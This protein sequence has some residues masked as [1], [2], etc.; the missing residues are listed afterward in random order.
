MMRQLFVCFAGASLSLW[1]QMPTGPVVSP[2]WVINAFTQQPAPSTVAPGGIIW[3]NGINLSPPGGGQASGSPL[4]TKLTEAE[5]EVLI[6]GRSAPLYSV[7]PSR[8][9]AQV[10]WEVRAGLAQVVVRRGGDQSR[11][12]RIFVNNMLPALRARQDKGYGEAVAA[13]T[14]STMK[15][16]ATGLGDTDP[17]VA[18]G[19]TG[20]AD[21]PAAPRAAVEVWVGGARSKTTAVVSTERV[22]EFDITVEI[23]A[24]ANPG[25]IITLAAGGRPSNRLTYRNVSQA[26]VS[27][28]P[29]PEDA[30]EMRGILSSDLRGDYV[31]TSSGRNEEGCWPAWVFDFRKKAVTKID[32]CLVAANRNAAMPFSMSNEGSALGAL[33]GPAQGE[34]Q[35]GISSKV[36]VLNPS[37]G[38]PMRLDL[39]AAVSNVAS[40]PG[41]NLNAVAPGTPPRAFRIDVETGEVTEMP[42]GG[43]AGGAGAGAGG[44]ILNLA[45]DLGDGLKFPLTAPT[46]VATN[47]FALVVGNDEDKPTKARF[48]VMNQRGELLRSKEFPEG[49]VPLVAPEAAGGDRPGLVPGLGGQPVQA[50]RFRTPFNFD[51][52]SRTYYV[53]STKTDNSRHALSAFPTAGDEAAAAIGFPAGWFAASCTQNIRLF[54]FELS[55]RLAL[56]ASNVAETE[57]KN[58]CPALGFGVL[59]LA[60]QRLEVIPLPGEGRFNATGASSGEVNDY[61]YGTN[62]DPSRRNISDTLYILD[63]VT[64]SVFRLDLPPEVTSFTSLSPIPELGALIGLGVSRAVGDVGL[65]FFDFENAQA[66]LL[67]TPAGFATVAPIDFFPATRKLVARGVKADN[68]G[69]QLLVYD[70]M[71]GD[72]A[73]VPNPA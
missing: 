48:A 13:V 15:L 53:L 68:A 59:N 52:Q 46:A 8:I 39:G 23:P 41:G 27:W 22:G 64:D 11:P 65:L 12:A 73:I 28:L 38:E 6:N 7:S 54:T 21:P 57:V 37:K 19:T 25:D 56:L 70:L 31:V 40:A 16:S 69:S 55:R 2:R 17:D 10:P 71:T 1:G 9:V 3:I 62:T 43:A 35:E 51:A 24:D 42:V 66:R 58:P 26:Q 50:I 20:P 29:F 67:P 63:G 30:P 61:I 60:N 47:E 18:S 32:D 34:V 36:L 33:I 14:G 44:G 5:V 4:P 72:L 49:F 45:I